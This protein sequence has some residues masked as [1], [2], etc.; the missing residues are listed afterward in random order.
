MKVYADL[1]GHSQHRFTTIHGEITFRN[2]SSVA[3]FTSS[4]NAVV[5]TV[6][7]TPCL[8]DMMVS[9]RL[10]LTQQVGGAAINRTALASMFNNSLSHD[11]IS[12]DGSILGCVE[13]NSCIV[14]YYDIAVLAYF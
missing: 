8:L 3:A 2:A 7:N 14:I 6:T 13:S 1:A 10:L 5:P 4:S 9:V 12:Y 11:G